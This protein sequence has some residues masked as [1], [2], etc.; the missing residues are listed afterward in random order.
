MG[1]FILALMDPFRSPSSARRPNLSIQPEM[2]RPAVEASGR[3]VAGGSAP[4]FIFPRRGF[5]TVCVPHTIRYLD[6]QDK[7]AAL[8]API[9]TPTAPRIWRRGISIR[10]G[11]AALHARGGGE[12]AV[13]SRL[14]STEISGDEGDPGG[15]GGSGGQGGARAAS[16]VRLHQN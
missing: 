7:K 9:G 12:L 10:S 13:F 15:G 1:S 8:I 6:Q 4:T 3:E 5:A 16:P 11:H 14:D 2:R